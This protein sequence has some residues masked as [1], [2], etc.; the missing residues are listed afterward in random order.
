[1]IFPRPIAGTFHAN[2]SGPDAIIITSTP[3]HH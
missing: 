2:I 3:H 1:M